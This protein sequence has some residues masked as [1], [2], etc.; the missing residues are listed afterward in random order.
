VGGYVFGKK[1]FE[2]QFSKNGW[3]V[4][5]PNVILIL[6]DGAADSKR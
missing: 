2:N 6:E 1:F 4:Q 3:A 5:F